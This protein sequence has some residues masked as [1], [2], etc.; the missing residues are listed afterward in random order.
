MALAAPPGRARH[1]PDPGLSSGRR[2]RGAL[3]PSGPAL[4]RARLSRSPLGLRAADT[5]HSC[6]RRGQFCPGARHHG[7]VGAHDR[8]HRGL[9]ASDLVHSNSLLRAH[10]DCALA[11]RLARRPSVIELYDLVRPGLG[12]TVLTAAAALS[13]TAWPSPVSRG[14]VA[15]CIGPAAAPARAHRDA[16]LSVD[17]DRFGPGLKPDRPRC[18]G[19]SP[20]TSGRRWSGSW[21]G[22][23]PKKASTCSSGPWACSG[24]RRRVPTW[25]WWAVAGFSSRRLPWSGCGPRPNAPSATGCA[26][27]AAPMQTFPRHAA[28]PST[29]S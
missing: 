16:L 23:T 21:V 26:S 12:R 17:L 2:P 20:P 15:D 14:A 4:H 13:T 11:G 3:A 10:L 5:E 28:R 6:P 29:S 9:V 7:P 27:S 18:A 22:S 24:A 8:P 19:T 1:R 25:S